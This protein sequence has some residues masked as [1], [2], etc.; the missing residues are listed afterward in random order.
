MPVLSSKIAG[1]CVILDFVP[2]GLLSFDTFFSSLFGE[3]AGRGARPSGEGGSPPM[4]QL[5]DFC[6]TDEGIL[7][8]DRISTNEI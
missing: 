1:S 4:Q 8:H 5:V 2:D 7:N 3:L 6:L